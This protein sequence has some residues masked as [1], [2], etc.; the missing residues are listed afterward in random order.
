MAQEKYGLSSTSTTLTTTTNTIYEEYKL[1]VQPIS[2]S[3]TEGTGKFED[4]PKNTIG[5][6]WENRSNPIGANNVT[7]SKS[8]G[9]TNYGVSTAI[10]ISSSTQTFSNQSTDCLFEIVVS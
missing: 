10:N 9:S 5:T 7:W 4:N 8:D 3:W 6:S 1:A 2:Q